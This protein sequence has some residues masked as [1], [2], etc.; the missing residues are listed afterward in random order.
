MWE[1]ISCH[2]GDTISI[3]QNYESVYRLTQVFCLIILSFSL[4]HLFDFNGTAEVVCFE[5]YS[6]YCST[7]TSAVDSGL[8]S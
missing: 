4:H 3:L 7:P 1:G 8:G 2:A 5:L 6:F